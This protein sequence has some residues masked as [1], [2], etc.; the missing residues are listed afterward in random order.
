MSELDQKSDQA[1]KSN[2]K[3]WLAGGAAGI[4]VASAIGA[5]A[6][7][8]SKIYSHMK[9]E[10]GASELISWRGHHRKA[11]TPEEIDKRVERMVKHL[12]IEVDA[13]D[14]QETKLIGLADALVN[15][16]MLLRG[17]MRDAGETLQKI[18]SAPI[19]DRD[20]LES[21]RAERFSEAENV[22][23][24]LTSAIADAAEV[25]TQEQRK[26]LSERIETFRS[27]RGHWRKG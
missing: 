3:I 17:N 26:T 15:D 18:L 23:K 13:N 21:L 22:S 12:A 25:L 14:E 7:T 5:Q 6:F 1:P 27:M 11:M 4:I 16:V 9:V 2:R 10:G 8:S 24:K 19:I 20:A